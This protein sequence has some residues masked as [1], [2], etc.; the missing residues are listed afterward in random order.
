MLAT[1]EFVHETFL[2]ILIA[3]DV[4]ISRKE[5]ARIIFYTA[6]YLEI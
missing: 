5:L 3:L 6:L 2:T 4:S 1:V